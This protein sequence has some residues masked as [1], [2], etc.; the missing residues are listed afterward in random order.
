MTAL[1][2]YYEDIDARQA[3]ATESEAFDEAV[4]R[5][6]ELMDGSEPIELRD[7]W[8]VHDLASDALWLA[9]KEYGIEPHEV[10]TEADVIAA[11]VEAP[12]LRC[13]A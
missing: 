12:A 8:Y 4:A 6:T 1:G 7:N 9:A 5:L 2:L 11:L 3:M 10:G 13:A